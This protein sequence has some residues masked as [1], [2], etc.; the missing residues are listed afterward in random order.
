MTSI[1]QPL[2]IDLYR[3]VLDRIEVNPQPIATANHGIVLNSG[4]IADI[5]NKN[6]MKCAH[7]ESLIIFFIF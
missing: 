4:R 3:C 6:I 5:T 7:I 2:P 1:V